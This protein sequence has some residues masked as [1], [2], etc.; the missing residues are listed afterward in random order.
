MKFEVTAASF[1]FYE[2][3]SVVNYYPQL[4]EFYLGENNG[5]AIVEIPSLES[6]MKLQKTLQQKLIVNGNVITIYDDYIE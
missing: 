5:Y 6:L 2:D 4:R 3:D 1:G